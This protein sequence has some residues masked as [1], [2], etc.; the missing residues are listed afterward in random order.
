[1]NSLELARHSD[2]AGEVN[3]AI[4]NYMLALNNNEPFTSYDLLNASLLFFLVQDYGFASKYDIS[5]DLASEA[6]GHCLN[7]LSKIRDVDEEVMAEAEFWEL[8]F[9][10][11]VLGDKAFDESARSLLKKSLVPVIYLILSTSDH[12][13]EINNKAEALLKRVSLPKVERER[14]IKSILDVAR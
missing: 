3:D 13:G 6:W 8:Y 9:P 12:T 10:F 2:E 11:I 4:V 1:M 14:Y 5:N 7:C